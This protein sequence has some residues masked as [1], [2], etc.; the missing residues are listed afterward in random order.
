MAINSKQKGKSWE[1]ALC[2]ILKER[3]PGRDFSRVPTSGAFFGKTNKEKRS[4]AEDNVKEVLSGDIICPSDFRFSIECKSYANISFWDLFNE[5]SDLH[6]WM[7]QCSEDA[8]FVNKDPLLVVKINNHKPFVAIKLEYDGYVF[9]HRGFF[10]YNL[11]DLLT[12]FDDG[13]FFF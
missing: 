6:S 9:E 5:S 10:F 11:E 13:F 12:K 3:F 1:R 2:K 4:L 7:K 8:A